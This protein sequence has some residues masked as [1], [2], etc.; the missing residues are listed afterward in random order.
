MDS[1]QWAL[2]A[3]GGLALIGT[4]YTAWQTRKGKSDETAV[5]H[6]ANSISGFE[7]NIRAFDLRAKNAET[8]AA[9]AL[10]RVAALE[11]KDRERDRQFNRVRLVIQ[12]WFR[13]LLATWPDHTPMPLPAEED[14]E[15]LGITLPKSQVEK[16]RRAKEKP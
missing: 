2:V 10:Q 3:V 1:G 12:T 7:A 6:E 16:L 8:S 14:L 15:L 5:D 4:V 9:E 11:Q 13:E